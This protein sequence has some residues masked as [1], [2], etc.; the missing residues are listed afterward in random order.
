VKIFIGF[1]GVLVSAQPGF[2]KE[3]VN[4]AVKGLTWREFSPVLP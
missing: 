2:A 1:C 3:V 4:M